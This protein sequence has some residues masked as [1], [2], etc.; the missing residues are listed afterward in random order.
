MDSAMNKLHLSFPHI[1]TYIDEALI[2]ACC[3]NLTTVFARHAEGG[4]ENPRVH[5]LGSGV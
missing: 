4:D 2:P 3:N 1:N 5:I